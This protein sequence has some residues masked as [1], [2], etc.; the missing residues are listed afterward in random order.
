MART[1]RI[2]VK[3]EPH[4]IASSYLNRDLRPGA[5]L[6]VAAPRGDFVLD[7]GTGPILLISAGI[8]VTPVLSMLHQL[9]AASS[10]RDI[11]WIH[12]ARG[13]QEH[14]F[15]A[16][17]H[18]LLAALPHAREHVFYSAATPPE[19]CRAHA[20]PGASPETSWPGW[21]SRPARAPT[22]AGRPRSWPTCRT[23]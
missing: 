15:A 21:P 3:Q 22:S 23:P 13:P 5:I 17:A 19:R 20:D 18:A 12:G 7:D 8:G 11:W 16:E 2:S 1:Y 4:G 9:A 14:P 10:E 6:D